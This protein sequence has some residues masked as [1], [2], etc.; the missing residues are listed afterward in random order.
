MARKRRRAV[1]AEDIHYI[2]E[3]IF[4]L[5]K[6]RQYLRRAGAHQPDIG[7]HAASQ[8][9][10]PRDVARKHKAGSFEK[11]TDVLQGASEIEL[12]DIFFREQERRPEDH[13]ASADVDGTQPSRVDRGRARSQFVLRHER[14]GVHRQVSEVSRVP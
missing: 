13:F 14:A 6:A 8:R 3:G 1:T 4:A 9:F 10:K 12:V 5:G 11:C 7:G 2:K